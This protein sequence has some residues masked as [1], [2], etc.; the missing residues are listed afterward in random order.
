MKQFKSFVSKAV[1]KK[2]PF[3]YA[4]IGNQQDIENPLMF[5]N[6]HLP[7]SVPEPEWDQDG[8]RQ[9]TFTENPSGVEREWEKISLETAQRQADNHPNYVDGLSRE[10]R[11]HVAGYSESSNSLNKL[12]IHGHL[13]DLDMK[14][15]KHMDELHADLLSQQIITEK[16]M[17]KLYGRHKT[18]SRVIA[19]SP[20]T[21]ED[22]DVYTGVGGGFDVDQQRQQNDGLIHL[23][24]YTSTTLNPK[25]A[26]NFAF[27]HDHD[28]P[29]RP[30]KRMKEIIHLRL[31][32][33][34][35][36]TLFFGKHSVY[37]GEHEILLRHGTTIRL[38]GT[39]RVM[40][41]DPVTRYLIHSGTI[42]NE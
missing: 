11:T 42:V 37:P 40:Q 5:E 24:A 36:N 4:G 28:Y 23:P 7:H 12:L 25:I 1:D 27:Q 14:N 33:G 22:L 13:R 32:K 2:T 10:D 35:R 41:S 6:L 21:Q 3:L 34:T 38:H 15:F 39:P 19:G 30:S 29:D 18:L 20:E 8:K 26:K 16:D 31:P 9:N 17:M